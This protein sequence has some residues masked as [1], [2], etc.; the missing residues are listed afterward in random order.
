MPREIHAAGVASI[1][2]PP[3]VNEERGMVLRAKQLLWAPQSL[4]NREFTLSL[5][6]SDLAFILSSMVQTY[7][8]DNIVLAV[9]RAEQEPSKIPTDTLSGKERK[10][11]PPY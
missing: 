9:M 2:R 1:Q 6:T 10:N 11:A 5:D 7:G 4:K 8:A 3:P